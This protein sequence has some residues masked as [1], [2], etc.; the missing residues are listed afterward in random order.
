MDGTSGTSAS[1]GCKDV[2]AAVDF[3]D[4]AQRTY[5]FRRMVGT[6]PARYVAA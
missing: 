3:Y 2:A 4:Q 6:T 1:A 5:H